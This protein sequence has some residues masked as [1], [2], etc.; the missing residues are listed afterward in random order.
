[1]YFVKKSS[2]LSSQ[3]IQPHKCFLLER[4]EVL[5]HQRRAACVPCFVTQNTKIGVHKG[6]DEMELSFPCV[7]DLL[8]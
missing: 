2:W 7:K 8:K 3:L 1:M 6:Q 4:T 5:Q